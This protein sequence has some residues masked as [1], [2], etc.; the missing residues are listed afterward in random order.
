MA[1]SD[2][3]MDNQQEKL[4]R[5]AQLFAKR[6]VC[7]E[8]AG[9]LIVAAERTLSEAPSLPNI[10]FHLTLLA[11]EEMGK[12]GLI[13]SR[14]A[15]AGNR[16][17]GW[18]DKRLDDHAFKLLWGLWTPEM[19]A[20]AEVSPER[21]EQLRKFA[22]R[23]HFQRLD[24]LYVNEALDDAT[25][26]PKDAVSGVEAQSLLD[27]AKQNLKFFEG[28]GSPDVDASDDVVEWFW[29]TMSDEIGQKRLFSGLFLAKYKELKNKPREWIRWARDEFEKVKEAEQALLKAE[30]ARTPDEN[31]PSTA[32]WRL[33]VRIYC[34]SHSIRPKHL[35]AWN[36]KVPLAKLKFV[37]SNE[38]LLELTLG[39]H[40]NLADIHDSGMSLSKLII[41]CLNIGTAGFFWYEIPPPSTGYFQKIDDLA[42]P[43]MKVDIAKGFDLQR[44]WLNDNKR[45]L[46]VLEDTYLEHAAK[47]AVVFG[48]M[49]DAE[50]A[51]IF[52]RY[53]YGLTMLGKSDMHLSLDSHAYAAFDAALRS[54][55]EHFRDW[56][57][58]A[59][60]LMPTLQKVLSSALPDAEHRS[61]ILAHF[62]RPP[63]S[64]EE[65]QNYTIAAKRI[66]DL[67]LVIVANRLWGEKLA[68]AMEA[69]K[70]QPRQ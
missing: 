16:Y 39:D 17:T 54:A 20:G 9:D 7:F 56:T 34:V 67:Y 42:N 41:C 58:D 48:S 35:N 68:Q 62:L 8:H 18:I 15:A 6:K 50:A 57:G 44:H 1:V 26:S 65:M 11:I 33:N 49:P 4:S 70:Q 29:E 59:T 12:A 30:L 52:G 38:M 37:K 14:E 24:A 55:L 66:A 31:A 21:F 53:L 3:L 61:S 32:R 69:E 5:S 60:T 25:T 28:E 36:E 10:S 43:S 40:V 45:T 27:L 64:H 23:A 63:N 19:N 51:P 46:T 22:Q 47:C 2:G 13:S